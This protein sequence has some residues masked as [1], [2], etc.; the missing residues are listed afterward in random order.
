VKTQLLFER[1]DGKVPQCSLCPERTRNPFSALNPAVHLHEI[2]CP[3]L[4]RGKYSPELD[5]ELAKAVYVKENCIL[6]CAKCNVEFAN[7]YPKDKMIA[8]KM[9]LP[10]YAPEQI[11]AA[12]QRIAA[13]LKNPLSYIPRSV[14][15]RGHTYPILE[16]HEREMA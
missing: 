12:L 4:G 13:Q 16:T 15:Y 3:P 1:P 10:G 11:I 9:G 8:L 5:N 6:L 7:S 14:D 2:V